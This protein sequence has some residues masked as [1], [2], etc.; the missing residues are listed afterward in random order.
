MFELAEADYAGP[1]GRYVSAENRYRQLLNEY[2]SSPL[3]P[4]AYYRLGSVF[5]MTQRPDSAL[6][7]FQRILDASPGSR[8]APHARLGRVE[9]LVLAARMREAAR[10]ADALSADRP[11]LVVLERLAVLNK[12]LRGQDTAGKFWVRVGVF[13]NGANLRRISGRLAGAG[14]PV[15]EEATTVPNLRILLVGP[16]FHRAAAA[17]E[18]PRVEREGGVVNC[19]IVERR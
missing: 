14:F 7:A 13:G 1:S 17:R 16:F 8:I 4:R 11:P 12:Q 9:A 15:R 5:L 2:S 6:A 19:L 3:A 10:E 18:L